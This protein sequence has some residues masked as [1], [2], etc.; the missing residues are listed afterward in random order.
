MAFAK[1][2]RLRKPRLR[3]STVLILRL[4]PSA[5]PLVARLSRIRPATALT[6]ASFSHLTTSASNRAVY[7]ELPSAHGT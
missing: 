3:T 6:L 2:F 5:D 1:R 4:M 7:L